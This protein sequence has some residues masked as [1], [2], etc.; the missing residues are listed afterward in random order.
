MNFGLNLHTI[1]ADKPF[2]EHLASWVL[3]TCGTDPA[4]LP[5]ALILLP[6]RRA[7]RSLREAFLT[8]SGGKPM[9]LPRIQ[10]L[11]DIEEMLAIPYENVNADLPPVIADTRREF[12]LTQLVMDFKKRQ[13]EA[14]FGRV[15]NIEQATS[16]A[17]QLATLVDDA[18]RYGISFEHLDKLVPEDLAVHW[19]QTL[20]FLDIISQ[21]WPK[22][23]ESEGV[24]DPVDHRNRILLATAKA[25][26]KQAPDMPVIAAGSTGSTPATAALL[27]AIAASPQG[28]V[29]LPGLDIDMSESEWQGLNE[30][31][32]QFGMKQLLES[33]GATRAG[34]H[35]LGEVEPASSRIIALR[36]ILQSPE[37]TSGWSREKLPLAEGL[38]HIKL[39]TAD[40]LHDEARMI[41]IALRHTLETPGETAALVTPDRTLARMVAAQMLSF[42]VEIDDSAGHPLAATPAASFMKL[43]IDMVAAQAAPVE[44]LAL[45]RHPL[46]AA[47]LDTAQCRALSRLLETDLLRGLRREPGL[48]PLC[49]ATFHGSLKELLGA[50]E[51]NLRPLFECFAMRKIS[52]RQ[53]IDAHI[54]CSEF[55][56]TTDE[57]Q[58]AQR[59]WN[60]DDGNAMVEFLADIREHADLLSEIDPV[61]YPAL[62]GVLL[63][64]KT[65]YPRF[66]L[67]PRLHILSPME[68]RLQQ[69]DHVI[70]GGLNEGTWPTPPSI[71]PWMSRPMR[72]KFGLPSAARTVGQSAHDIYLL[73]NG[74]DVLL[75]RSQKVD[76]T[77]TVPSRWLVRL[78]TLVKGQDA[79]LYASMNASAW[80]EQGK[81]KLAHA[82]PLPAITRPHPVPPLAARPRKLKVTAIDEWIA[83]PYRVYAR[84][85]LKLRSLPELDQDPDAADFGNL[86]HEALEQFTLKYSTELPENTY[87]ELL[88]FGREAFEPMLVYPAVTSLWWPRFEAMAVWLAETESSRRVSIAKVLAEIKGQWDFE[89]DGKGFTLTTKIDRIEQLKDG[90]LVI[91][92][93]KTGAAPS[94]KDIEEGRK[95]QI[96]NEALIVAH[97]TLEPPLAGPMPVSKLEYWKLS[98]RS[99][100]AKTQEVEIAHIEMARGRLEQLIRLFDNPATAYAPPTT[101][102]AK[103][104]QYNDYAHLTRR[105]EWGDV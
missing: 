21:A 71:D 73:C 67:H 100:A 25:W 26:T 51:N 47:G 13:S 89:V 93:Y 96:L 12:L 10:P 38:S 35:A 95:N 76:G 56:A 39:L 57:T 81:R 101:T 40:T 87:E 46:T 83:D 14:F 1:P 28:R 29:V 61:S 65:Y 79:A 75:S 42:G 94:A 97:G 88:R 64:G 66:G 17:R 62:L 7:C 59:L 69:F 24:L 55:L 90:T 60:G 102:S 19:Q 8:I 11:G 78:E 92:D 9:L 103:S 86:V 36:A 18:N 48:K 91:A 27:S 23:L 6:S 85:I 53:M 34:V 80:Y 70:L 43:L 49:D 84:H 15:F 3:Q 54:A 74:G 32:P 45:L 52:F 4:T 68:S 30:T 63:S 5:R 98:G 2:I 58:G 20:A 44:L 37:A 22:I 31:H 104:E 82:D 33:M 77:P 41:A 50:L 99:E 72:E 16:L 105:A